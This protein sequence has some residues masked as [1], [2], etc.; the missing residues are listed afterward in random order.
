MGRREYPAVG[1][2]DLRTS[3]GATVPVGIVLA[4]QALRVGSV[5]R[6]PHNRGRGF[7]QTPKS[8][9]RPA[10]ATAVHVGSGQGVRYFSLEGEVSKF[11]YDFR[12]F[13]GSDSQWYITIEHA[14][15]QALY[16]S[17]GYTREASAVETLENFIR[18]VRQTASL[19]VT[20]ESLVAQHTISK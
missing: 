5:H 3:A 8:S 6:G 15:G 16:T 4:R 12:L 13:Q 17:E 20:T 7:S 9:R 1:V 10:V 18:A 19:E 14:N 2:V 11:D